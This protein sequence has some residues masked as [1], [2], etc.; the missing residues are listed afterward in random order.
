MSYNDSVT[1]SITN[2]YDRRGRHATVARN[3]MTTTRSLN[4]AGL[5]LSESYSGIGKCFGIIEQDIIELKLGGY[6]SHNVRGV[7]SESIDWIS[8]RWLI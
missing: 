7:W 6:M 2:G 3:S 5:V 8:F 4:D 1:A